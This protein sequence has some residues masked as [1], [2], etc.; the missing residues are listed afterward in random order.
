MSILNGKL[1]PDGVLASAQTPAGASTNSVNTGRVYDELQVSVSIATPSGTSIVF[2][3][4]RPEQFMGPTGPVRPGDV[5]WVNVSDTNNPAAGISLTA[6]SPGGMFRVVQ[7][8]G[9]Y[10]VLVTTLLGA[11]FSASYALSGETR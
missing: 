4:N 7:P 8:K 2:L 3:Q 9:E 11:S 10:Q 6:A 5:G 1:I